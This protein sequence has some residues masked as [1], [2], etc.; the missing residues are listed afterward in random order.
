MVSTKLEEIWKG[1]EISDSLSHGLLYRRYSADVKPD[2]FVSLR[3]PEKLRCISIRVNK[4]LSINEFEVNKF[5]DIKFEFF[6]DEQIP[7]K[8]NLLILLLNNQFKDIFSTLCEDLINHVAD[9]SKEKE[10]VDT[11]LDRLIK[12]QLLFEIAGRK[13]LSSEAQRGLY[14]ELFFLRLFLSSAKDKTKALKTWLGPEKAIQDF[15]YA[16][17]AVE[18]KTTHGK[19][20]QKI[21]V[22]SERQLDDSIVENIFLVH[23]SLEIRNDKGETLNQIVFQIQSLLSDSQSASNLFKLKLYEYGY[24][25]FESDLYDHKGYSIR[26]ENYYQVK[27]EFPRIKEGQIPKGVGD[28]TYSIILSESEEWRADR[29][30]VIDFINEKYGE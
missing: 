3:V 13:G 28:V 21:H 25:E 6:P 10:L 11:I 22:T 17:W 9:L 20:H 24:F 26:Q 5:R 15:Q 19:N 18:V 4:E 1:L 27:G 14:G 12:W 2:V 16:D 7:E 8:K 30:F 23:L 29:S